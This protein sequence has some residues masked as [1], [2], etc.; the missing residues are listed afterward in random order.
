MV[1][2]RQSLW[3]PL[4][5]VL[6][7]AAAI[8]TPRTGETTSLVLLGGTLIVAGHAWRRGTR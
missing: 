1:V 8:A 5:V 6:A 3:V 4:F 2:P 7:A